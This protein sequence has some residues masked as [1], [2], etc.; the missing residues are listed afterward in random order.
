MPVGVVFYQCLTPEQ[1]EKRTR[2]LVYKW[3]GGVCIESISV[4]WSSDEL[5]ALTH[6]EGSY[7]GACL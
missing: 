4:V 6:V 1:E 3:G 7:Y 2:T 5:G